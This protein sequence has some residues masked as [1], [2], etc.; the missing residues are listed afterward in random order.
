MVRKDYVRKEPD[1][2]DC[3][4]VLC[5]SARDDQDGEKGQSIDVD[6]PPAGDFAQR[7]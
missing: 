6:E 2:D 7:R 3:L 4:Y 5:D 1:H